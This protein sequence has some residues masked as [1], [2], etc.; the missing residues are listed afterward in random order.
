MIFPL[1]EGFLSFLGQRLCRE[2]R[3]QWALLFSANKVSL[4]LDR[5]DL[6][7]IEEEV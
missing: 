3:P 7:V 4:V 1:P 2:A 6:L 5:R